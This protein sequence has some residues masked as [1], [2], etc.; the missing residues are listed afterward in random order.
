[1]TSAAQV[2]IIGKDEPPVLTIATVLAHFWE[3]RTL[4]GQAVTRP[5][6]PFDRDEDL[7]VLCDSFTEEERQ[8]W[9]DRVRAVSSSLLIVKINGYD[10]GPH[11]GADATV[12]YDHGPAALVSTIYEL[13]TERGLGHRAWEEQPPSGWVQ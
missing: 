2:L 12:D 13:L 9:V 4:V 8:Q 11:A 10:S 1:M 5:D 3:T 6:E 7:V